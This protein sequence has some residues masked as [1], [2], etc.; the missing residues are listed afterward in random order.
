MRK[1]IFLFLPFL[2]CGI[3]SLQAQC[4]LFITTNFDSECLLTEYIKERPSLWEQD[5]GNCLL[6]C[7]GN[8]VQYTAV[9]SGTV[10]QYSWTISGASSYYFT[11][12]NKTAVVTWDDYNDI[13]NI[14]VNVVTSDTNS[15]TEEV[16]VLLMESP[17]I[18]SNTVPNY[19]NQNGQKVIEVCRGQTIELMDMSTTGLTPIVGYQW[20]TPFGDASTPDHTIVASQTGD[21]IIKHFV[22]NECGCEGYEEI[23][24]R[25]VEELKLELSCYGTVCAGSNETYTLLNP[26]C[27]QYM[28]SVEGGTYT[29]VPSDPATIDVQWGN[30]SSGYGVISIDAAFCDAPCKA[31]ASI[32]IPVI[33]NNAEIEGPDVV[34]VGDYQLYELPL[35]GSTYYLWSINPSVGDSDMVNTEEINQVLLRFQQPGSY[36]LSARYGC[37]FIPCGPDSTEKTIIVKDT[38]S[39]NSDDNTLCKGATGHYTTWHGNSVTWRVY[40]QN[41]AQIYYTNGVSLNYTFANAGRYKIVASNSNYCDDAEYLVTVLDNPPALTITNGPHSACPNSSILLNATPTHPNYY[42]EWVQLCAPNN[43]ENGDEVTIDYGNT[44]CDVAVYQIDGENECRSAAYIHQ[45]DAFQLAPHG[46][47]AVTVACAGST[48]SFAVPDQS[49]NVTYEWNVSPTNAASVIDNHLLPSVNILTNHLS[50][51][52]PYTITV[53]LTR[54]PCGGSPVNETV[55]IQIVGVT[56]PALT[57]NDIVCQDAL[58]TFTATGGSSVSSDYTWEFSDTALLF[59]GASFNRTFH[60]T[61]PVTFTLT[62]QPNPNCD[63]VT[64]T[65]SLYVRALPVAYV[66]C[67][68]TTLS[69]PNQTNM[70]YQWYHNGTLL[71][72]C[73]TNIFIED[74]NSFNGT[75]CCTVSYNDNPSCEVQGCYTV[76][77]DPPIPCSNLVVSAGAPNCNNVTVTAQNVPDAQYMWII[78]TSASGSHITPDGTF[79]NVATATFSVPGIYQVSVSAEANNQ[80][81]YGNSAPITIDCIPKFELSYDCNGNIE[82][83]DNSLYRTGYT[84]P[85]RR[86]SVVGTLDYVD[87]TNQA[88]TGSINVGIPTTSTT[89]TINMT[90]VGSSCT[91]TA[92]ITIEPNPIIDSVV[93]SHYMCENTPFLFNAYP[94]NSNYEYHWNFG[95][96]SYNVGNGIYHSYEHAST[97]FYVT[98]TVTNSIGCTATSATNMNR[99]YTSANN[100]IGGYLTAEGTDVCPGIPRQ[101]YFTPNYLNSHYY[102]NSSLYSTTDNYYNTTQ[103]GDYHVLVITSPYGCKKECILNVGFLNAPTARITGNTTYCLGEEVRLNGNTGSTNQYLWTISGSSYSQTF[104]TSNITFTPTQPGTYYVNLNVTSPDGCV[105]SAACTVTVHQQPAAPPIAFYNNQCIHTP[106]VYVHSTASPAQSLLWSNGF[107]GASAQYYVPGYLT[108]HYID[109]ATGCPS[110]K[111]TLFIPPAPNYDALLTGCYEKCRD[112]LPTSLYVYNLYPYDT[113]SLFWRWF[114]NNHQTAQGNSGQASLPI[115]SFGSYYMNTQYGNGCVA[116]SPNLEI[117]EAMICPCDSIWVEVD[118][119]CSTRECKLIYIM[120]V[121]I[122]NDGSQPAYFSQLTSNTSSNIMYVTPMP[123][124]V[125]PGGSQTIIVTLE[126]TDF[127]NPYIEFTLSDPEND[128]EYSFSE[129]FDWRRCVREDCDARIK[130]I[131]FL[132]Q[133]SSPHQTSYFNIDLDLPSGTTSLVAL[134]STPPQLITYSYSPPTYVNGLLMLNY[135]QLTQM[136]QNGEYVCFNAIVCIENDHLCY[137]RVCVKAPELLALIPDEFRQLSDSTTADNDSTRSL[138]SSSFIPQTDKP[139]LA[140]NPARDEVTVMGIAPEEVAEITVLTMQGGQVAEFRNDYHFNV[141]RLAKASYIVRVVTTDKQVY[142]LKLVKQ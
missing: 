50:I 23:I 110:A 79:P 6:A 49:E 71:P 28:W 5:F 34:C 22:Q 142:Y 92:S 115:G 86:Y 135:G 131:N 75:Y 59:H 95:D 21:F 91:Y 73:T 29:T 19:Y 58:E 10:S 102:W 42:L 126:F 1:F 2:I 68:G 132:S 74:P 133:L 16:C 116:Q 85:N 108:A 82:I 45:V 93:F 136:V 138:Q 33:T 9:C 40:N 97:P 72:S 128:C 20:I 38:M 98:L 48:V 80:C 17:T 125:A 84:I 119:W 56:A 62:Y 122:H 47:P 77:G 15:C 60:T 130:K 118:K 13:G 139:Y 120:T 65:G 37:D 101:I 46:L 117:S 41:N 127:A 123:V 7:K 121:T 83:T 87:L 54:T 64:V 61:G 109:P 69:V 107:Y 43:T 25:V 106:P 67:S 88:L 18:G 44:V 26:Y 89:Y 76:P 55:L 27:S 137:V 3:S 31:M 51:N 104:T 35:W 134:W 105:R 24:L 36:T 32:K 11:N 39:I 103:T 111:S 14:S 66:F 30:P 124:T 8:T 141:S 53:T 70:S 4:D 90:M 112:E 99:I 78:S 63:A 113:T 12:Q 100:V 57:Y 140:P 94:D 129:Y 81:Y 114:E 96:N 52:P